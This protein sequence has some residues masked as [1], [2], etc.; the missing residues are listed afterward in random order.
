M[1]LLRL[2]LAAVLLAPAFSACHTNERLLLDVHHL[3][4]GK[5]A[6]KDVAQAHQKDLA[7]EGARGV[8]YQR[9][10]VDESSGTIFCLVEAPSAEAASAVHREA[11]GL[12]ADDVREVVPGILPERASGR[13]PLFM[14]THRV[15]PG[16]RAEDVAEA[17]RKDLAVQ[18]GHGVRFLNYWVDEAGG[19]IHCLAEAPNAE[20]LVATHREAHGLVPESVLPVVEG[21]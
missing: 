14:D 4:A 10:W 9:Y 6:L 16:V 19:C 3:G 2:A 15:A 17:H 8:D 13:L 7:V 12:V 21:H 11:H 1:K 18:A 20:A 5:V